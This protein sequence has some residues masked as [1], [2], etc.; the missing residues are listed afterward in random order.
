[1]NYDHAPWRPKRNGSLSP[2]IYHSKSLDSVKTF[3]IKRL[4]LTAC[5]F[6]FFKKYCQNVIDY[7]SSNCQISYVLGVFSSKHQSSLIHEK[8]HEFKAK[9]ALKKFLPFVYGNPNLEWILSQQ[10]D[11][12]IQ[13]DYKINYIR[14]SRYNLIQKVW[15]YIG[16]S[17]ADG[18]SIRDSSTYVIDFDNEIR[19]DLNHAIK[20]N[21]SSQSLVLSWDSKQCPT[22]DFTETLSSSI[23]DIN[24]YRIIHP[25][26]IIKAGFT[27]ISPSI[28]SLR[29]LQLFECYSIGDN[30]SVFFIRLFSFYFCDQVAILLAIRDI[31]SNKAFKDKVSW[32]DLHSSKIV[33][34]N[35]HKAEFMWYPK[36]KKV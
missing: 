21:Y 8:L 4:I 16:I 31:Y 20:E 1:M 15:E 18:C 5:D 32:I 10:K 9:N 30:S 13:W 27:A 25:Y 34:T 35:S 24:S 29:F 26:K 23:V 22:A 2:E 14:S 19:G 12:E 33:S 7:E 17:V 28:T 11:A 6:D 36:P 3:N